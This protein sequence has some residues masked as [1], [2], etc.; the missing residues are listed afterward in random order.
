M[1]AFIITMTNI[2]RV[3]DTDIHIMC[4]RYNEW[5]I[6]ISIVVRLF[7]LEYLRAFIQ[8]GHELFSQEEADLI[9]F[10]AL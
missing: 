5:N 6:F 4:D 2:Y 9:T 1:T 10:M 3:G 8:I 7:P